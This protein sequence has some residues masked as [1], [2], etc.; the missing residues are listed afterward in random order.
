MH[1]RKS[2]PWC[3]PFL[4]TSSA[5]GKPLWDRIVSLLV[6]GLS[7]AVAEAVHVAMVIGQPLFVRRIG[8]EAER[9]VEKGQPAGIRLQLSEPAV[10]DLRQFPVDVFQTGS[11]TSSNINLTKSSY[12][13]RVSVPAAPSIRTILSTW[14]RAATTSFPPPSASAPVSPCKKG[15]IR[16]SSATSGSGRGNQRIFRSQ[17]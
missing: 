3:L 10:S 7:Y 16:M 12:T 6:L 2:C 15:M 5:G 4:A 14:G 9:A 8:Q 13:W 1:A 17:L 11:G